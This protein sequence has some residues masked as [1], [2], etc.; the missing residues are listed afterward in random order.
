[1]KNI[2]IIFYILF[3]YQ[4]YCQGENNNWYFGDNAAVN[5]SN[6]TPSA[7]FNSNMVQLE[8]VASISNSNGDLLFYSNGVNVWDR[9]HNIM[10]NGGDLLGH[11]S[12]TQSVVIIPFPGHTNLY[13]LFT[14]YATTLT[15]PN[16]THN[17]YNYSIIDMNLNNGFGD[18]IANEKNIPILNQLGQPLLAN[19]VSEEAMT[20]TLN[21]DANG[22]WLLIPVTAPINS[23]YA[24]RITSNGIINNPVLSNINF[25]PNTFNQVGLIANFTSIK[26]NKRRNRIA[27]SKHFNNTQLFIYSFNNQTGTIN[28]LIGSC[29]NCNAY[30]T[31]FNLDNLLFYSSNTTGGLNVIDLETGNLRQIIATNFE[32]GLQIAK[33]NEIYISKYSPGLLGES[34]N[35]T[36]TEYLAP[37]QFTNHFLYMI[38]NSDSYLLSNFV[39][40]NGVFLGANGFS[41]YGLP[42]FNHI[43]SSGS[44]VENRVLSNFTENNA[45]EYYASL[46]II[47]ENNYIVDTTE[48][49]NLYAG[50]SLTL[51]P[52]THI[53]NNS[54][55]LCRIS[56]CNNLNKLNESAISDN[57]NKKPFNIESKILSNPKFDI[58]IF[59]NPVKNGVFY[60]NTDANAERTVTVFDV[61]GKQVLNTTTSESAINVSN[62]TAGVY[63]VQISEEG[64]TATKKLVIE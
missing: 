13:F 8:G 31:E 5:F 23:L 16:P 32:A 10:P 55:F 22:Y 3:S 6:T 43:I 58:N 45:N 60:I 56:P 35:I 51:R 39:T 7:L 4:S 40:S 64:N 53:N 1:M 29:S 25:N 63:M 34:K 12:S 52:N 57:Y 26:I 15:T 27:I 42:Q 46:N 49:V 38:S 54:N 9:N 24:Y 28:G 30:S 59:P 20:Y 14:S 19:N 61:L 50:N 18:I 11:W 48:S 44:C 62:L 21:G 33:N 36:E 2:L 17:P 41:G 47:T 37:Q